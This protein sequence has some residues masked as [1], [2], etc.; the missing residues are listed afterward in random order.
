MDDLLRKS[1]LCVESTTTDFDAGKVRHQVGWLV[2]VLLHLSEMPSKMVDGE[3]QSGE[4][5]KKR[6]I[7]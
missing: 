1:I 4:G 6:G 2:V 5:R 7:V 3:N